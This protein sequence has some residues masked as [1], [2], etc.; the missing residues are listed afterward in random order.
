MSRPRRS[1]PSGFE[2]RAGAAPGRVGCGW[3]A[4]QRL[5]HARRAPTA[6]MFGRANWAV[7]DPG[8]PDGVDH[9]RGGSREYRETEGE[10]G[11]C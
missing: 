10:M 9:S 3:S 11:H 8:K 2:R 4:E 1:F 7:H 6:R 5:D